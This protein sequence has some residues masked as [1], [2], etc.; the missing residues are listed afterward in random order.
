MISN[1]FSLDSPLDLQSHL[2]KKYHVNTIY[3]GVSTAPHVSQSLVAISYYVAMKSRRSWCHL[4]PV[5]TS[6]W[7][8]TLVT[9]TKVLVSASLQ[10]LKLVNF[11]NVQRR[12]KGVSNKFVLLRYQVRRQ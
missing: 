12:C 4:G 6:Q 9:V 8:V 5:V 3:N 1:G 7:R 11:I 2:R 10:S